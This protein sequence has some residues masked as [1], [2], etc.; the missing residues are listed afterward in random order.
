MTF[1][2]LKT[3]TRI[4]GI[5]RY[6]TAA[7]AGAGGGR[8]VRAGCVPPPPPQL[9]PATAT[10]AGAPRATPLP[11]VLLSCPGCRQRAAVPSRAGLC[12]VLPGAPGAQGCATRGAPPGLDGCAKER[13]GRRS[14]GRTAAPR[15]RHCPWGGRGAVGASGRLL[16]RPLRAGRKQSP[17]LCFHLSPALHK[18]GAAPAG[19]AAPRAPAPG[20][21]LPPARGLRVTGPGPRP[22]R[23]AGSCRQA[24]ARPLSLV[25]A[26]GR[27]D[28]VEPQPSPLTPP[29]RAKPR[30]QTRPGLV[31]TRLLG[32]GA[33]YGSVG[34]RSRAAPWLPRAGEVPPGAEREPR[35][36][37]ELQD[38]PGPAPPPDGT[39][40]ERAARPGGGGAPVRLPAGLRGCFPSPRCGGAAEDAARVPPPPGRQSWRRRSRGRAQDTVAA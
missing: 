40:R 12:R 39:R 28:A 18:S 29:R 35:T 5:R 3:R 13:R 11:G 20:P 34:A 8:K 36:L 23:R 37:R 26:P 16:P 6:Q 32:T 19:P 24:G 4:P 38:E 2:R 10:G 9:G 31:A 1:S 33:G 25:R 22:A 30:R 27:G 15:A 17:L 7:A 14:G 21:W